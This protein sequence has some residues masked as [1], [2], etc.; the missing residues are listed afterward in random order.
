[1]PPTT[2]EGMANADGAG[3]SV[4]HPGQ[5][6]DNAPAACAAALRHP[7]ARSPRQ[8]SRRTAAVLGLDGAMVGPAREITATVAAGG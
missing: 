2:V 3:V 8:P 4:A 5:R 1:M 6:V 7:C